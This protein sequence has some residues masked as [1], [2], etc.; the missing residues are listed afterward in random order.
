M[1]EEAFFFRNNSGRKLFA[2]FHSPKE[3]IQT[4][5]GFVF[6]SPTFGEKTKTYRILVNFARLLAAN[7]YSVLRFDFMGEGDSEGEFEETDIETRISDTKDAIKILKSKNELIKINLLG[8]RLGATIA[9]IVSDDNIINSV[10]LW[11]PIIDV[12]AYLYDYLRGNLSNQLLVHKKIILN[13]EQ[14]VNKILSGEKINVDGWYVT[15]SL[16]KQATRVDIISI[17]NRIDK[18]ILL[19]KF[20]DDS[21]RQQERFEIVNKK[22]TYISMKPEFTWNE[23]KYYNPFPQ[24]IFQKTLI[25][26]KNN[27]S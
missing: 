1:E 5:Q 18:P 27:L 3:Q 16:W 24:E 23:W 6:V 4:N 20:E 9:G 21:F 8:L 10:I 26:V 13:R 19:V 25:W 17:L 2:F 15:N 12:R 7:G 22:I 14:L 11:E